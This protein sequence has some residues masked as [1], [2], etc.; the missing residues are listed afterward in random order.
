M[1]G[2][3]HALINT[4]TI[5]TPIYQF[6]QYGTSFP[7][8]STPRTNQSASPI[9]TPAM[10]IRRFYH[11]RPRYHQLRTR[12]VYCDQCTDR[13]RCSDPLDREHV[14]RDEICG[15]C[16]EEEHE[17]EKEDRERKR[18]GGGGGGAGSSGTKNRKS[19]GGGGSSKGK[20][21]SSRMKKGGK[22]VKVE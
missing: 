5:I 2:S 11:C 3:H 7:R 21:S 13:E 8:R 15:R 10:C 16:I 18:G 9:L 6:K 19:A 12:I 22:I 17:R 20:G 1:M 4:D 14:V